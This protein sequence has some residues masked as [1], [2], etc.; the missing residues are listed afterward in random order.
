MTDLRS[1]FQPPR[2]TAPSSTDQ[3]WR[4]AYA[5]CRS[6]NSVACA[7]EYNVQQ[8]CPEKWKAAV[9]AGKIY[10]GEG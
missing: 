6:L 3:Q 5:I 2:A 4:A 9:E 7:C 10:A 1:V 8:P